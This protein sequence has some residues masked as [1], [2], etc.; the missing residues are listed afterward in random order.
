MNIIFTLAGK[1]KRFKS[2]G[3]NK[4]KFLL[5]IG[6][7]TILESII[8][9]FSEEDFFYFVFNK[10]QTLDYPEIFDLIKSRIKNFEIISIEP[11][12]KGPAY[13]TG[14]NINYLNL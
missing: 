10:K 1:S 8:E 6:A 9:M 7:K 12:E 4:P 13:I 3:F 11:H 5:K 14:K 2:E